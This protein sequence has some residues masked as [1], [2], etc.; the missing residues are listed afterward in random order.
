[1]DRDITPK[2]LVRGAFESAGL[3]RLPFVPWIFTHAAKLDQ[4]TV[5]NMFDDPTKYSRCLQNTRKLY[6]YDAISGSF[7]PSLELEICGSPI[8]WQ[9]DFETPVVRPDPDF[10]FSRL[11][12]ID[13]ESAGKT[14]RFGTVIESLR[15]INMVSGKNIA[16]AAVVSGPLTVAA[17]LTGRDLIQDFSKEPEQTARAVEAAAALI[18]KVVQVYCGLQLDII[19]IADRLITTCP[20]ALLS[21]LQSFLSPV[22][23][24]VRFYNAFS[25]LLPGN[26]TPSRLSDIIDLGFDSIAVDTI[27]M[28]DWKDIRGSRPCVLG[29]SIPS[30]LLVSGGEELTDYLEGFLP[31]MVETGVFL[32]TDWEVPSETPP[33]NFHQ[34]MEKVGR[35]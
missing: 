33:E 29:H 7:D 10:D 24:T 1:M 18:L 5:R 20:D 22:L 15:R 16:L 13:V 25:V 30:H 31:K 34:V 21:Q 2:K 12:E 26:T 23:N 32:T 4:V 3:P 14:G 35:D 8:D 19:A 17:G 6:G 11:K 27:R 28:N 9:G